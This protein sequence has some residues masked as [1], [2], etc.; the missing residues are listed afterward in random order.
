M[1]DLEALAVEGVG[2]E[3]VDARVPAPELAQPLILDDERRAV[4]LEIGRLA[5]GPDTPGGEICPRKDQDAG[6]PESPD[7]VGAPC[8]GFRPGLGPGL[9]RVPECPPE[10]GVELVLI[11]ENGG[12]LLPA[13]GPVD[14][15]AVPF[16]PAVAGPDVAAEVGGDVLP[17]AEGGCPWIFRGIVS[18][19]KADIVF[20]I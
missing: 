15:H 9:V 5:P 2:L 4:D 17:G 6:R 10:P 12:F 16:L 20:N 8:A 11:G 3:V 13:L 14:G 7:Q 19:W 1:D 18:P